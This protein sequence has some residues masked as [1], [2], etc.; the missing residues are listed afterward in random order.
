MSDY[1]N[2]GDVGGDTFELIAFDGGNGH[3]ASDA[4]GHRTTIRAAR[5]LVVEEGSGLAME[6]ASQFGRQG[7]DV[8]VV[9][10]GSEALHALES[11]NDAGS[12]SRFAVLV[13]D[14]RAVGTVGE[15]LTSRA[16]AIDPELRILMATRAGVANGSSA[17]RTVTTHHLIKPVAPAE[18]VKEVG[19][20]IGR[21]PVPTWHGGAAPVDGGWGGTKPECE[22]EQ[23]VLRR[24]SLQVAETL[25]TAMEAKNVYLRGHSRRIGALAA[26][27][28]E[29]LGLDADLVEQVRLAGRLHDVGKIGVREE[30]LNKVA[31][32]TPEEFAHIQTH[33]A[34]GVEILAPLRHMGPALTFIGDHH[35]R[36]DGS[37]YPAGLA[38]DAISLGGRIV[39]A[40]DAFDALTSERPYRAALGKDDAI[41]LLESLVGRLLD[42]A[43]FDALKVVVLRPSSLV[44]LE[45]EG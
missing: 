30:V 2:G 40:A 15:D 7:Y 5:M 42:P 36:W 19:Q 20:A 16:L 33:V 35:E 41:V 10:D 38:G 23:A 9:G 31:P 34:I 8:T 29:H 44:F 13:C 12:P 24:L 28:A 43:V 25:I 32:L 17:A 6:V 18:L 21:R 37:G 26:D 14:T 1:L 11:A 27:I 3:R 22:M 4:R 45:D 39:A